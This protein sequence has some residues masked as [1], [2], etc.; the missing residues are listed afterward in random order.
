MLRPL[1]VLALIAAMLVP[2][3]AL[4]QTAPAPQIFAEP[5]VITLGEPAFVGVE[6]PPGA[7][8]QIF[9]YTRPSTTYRLVRTGTISEDG[10]RNWEINPAGNTRLYAEIN[11]RSTRSVT[12]NVAFAVSIGV[13]QRLGTYRFTGVV[14]PGFTGNPVTL[15][16]NLPGGGATVVGRAATS[17]SG[18]W[19]IDRRF[20]G[21]GTF[22]F[23]AVTGG[24]PDNVAGRSRG[25]GLTVFPPVTASPAECRIVL[26]EDSGGPYYEY[27]RSIA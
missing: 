10:L 11:G 17:P 21:S 5:R 20:T 6:G 3:P 9:A 22:G 14:R 12:V 1:A 7:S 13:T 19:R 23:Y 4:A 27:C 8:V 18:I 24:F 15:Y 25:Y 16:R 26:A 2:A